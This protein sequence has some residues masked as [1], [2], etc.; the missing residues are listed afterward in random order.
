MMGEGGFLLTCIPSCLSISPPYPLPP[1]PS[2]PMLLPGTHGWAGY[3]L[4]SLVF[5]GEQ[6]E[7]DADRKSVV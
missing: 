2:S 4:I 7:D 6:V 1:S 5:G 3:G